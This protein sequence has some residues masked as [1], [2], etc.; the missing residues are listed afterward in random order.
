MQDPVGV[1]HIELKPCLAELL[2]TCIYPP[3]LLLKVEHVFSKARAGSRNSSPDGRV[4]RATDEK[5]RALCTSRPLQYNTETESSKSRCLHLALSDGILQI[6]A[7]FAKQLHNQEVL[8]LQRGDILELSDY[9][10]RIA[11][12]TTGQG[13]VIYFGIQHCAWVGREETTKAK[14]GEFEGGFF[15]EDQEMAKE[16]EQGLGSEGASEWAKATIDLDRKRLGKR[17][18]ETEDDNDPHRSRRRQTTSQPLAVA[19]GRSTPPTNC[20]NVDCDD[21]DS[22]EEYFDTLVA[23]QSQIEERRLMLRHSQQGLGKKE[24]PHMSKL[25][26]EARVNEQAPIRATTTSSCGGHAL[27]DTVQANNDSTN[28]DLQLSYGQPEEAK[29]VQKDDKR[30]TTDNTA[31]THMPSTA[32]SCSVTPTAPLHT[33]ASLLNPATSLPPR[34]YSCTIFCVISWVSSSLIHKANTPFPPKRH[35]KV[36]DPSVSHRQAGITVAIFVDA[37][38]FMPKPGTVA[39]LKDVVM[40]RCGDDVILNKYASFGS[41]T[42]D[43]SSESP[44]Q[45]H[46]GECSSWFISDEQKLL[47]LGLDVHRMKKWWQERTAKKKGSVA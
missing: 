25:Q 36:H 19:G 29:E 5:G 37:K 45:D 26:P 2:R 23:S 40:Q 11:A 16:T 31:V 17:C 3:R 42:K 10:L 8:N 47:Q 27:T 9:Q 20:W 14:L 43:V 46:S 6:Q 44:D 12:R 30:P 13:K 39:L 35:V 24:T 33:L 7:V 38:N 32:P 4:E 34:N 28:A 22:E 15:H 1:T 41:R 21:D 18:R